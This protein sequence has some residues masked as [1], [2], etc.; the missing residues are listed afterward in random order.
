M[1]TFALANPGIV[2]TFDVDGH[3]TFTIDL[4]GPR[5][6][7]HTSEFFQRGIE[8]EE[9]R[10]SQGPVSWGVPVPADALVFGA[11]SAVVTGLSHQFWVGWLVG[12]HLHMQALMQLQPID[13]EL[14]S[15]DVPIFPAI[16]D[17]SG[18]ANLY[19]WRPGHDKTALCRYSFAGQIKTA[20]KV[21]T[22][23]LAEIPG[24][25]VVS[26]GGTIPGEQ[27]QHAVIGWVEATAEGAVL[28]MA[29]VMPDRM[30][31][32]RSEPV[33]GMAPFARQRLGIWAAAP[34]GTVGRVQ[35]TAALQSETEQLAYSVAV[36]DVGPDS[37]K[38]SVTLSD[39]GIPVGT[40][41]SAAFDYEKNQLDPFF[42]RT[43]L[44]RDGTLLTESPPQVRHQNIDLDSPL[45]VV[46]TSYT[47][48]GTRA[49]DGTMTFEWF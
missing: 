41:H 32:V 18:I 44:T 27:S 20:G 8:L 43:F 21:T 7:L 46:S 33:K 48:W 31:L 47:Y 17:R 4:L 49:A 15:D 35:L 23:A 25:P 34:P 28:A 40:L 42:C 11:T 3:Q 26:V 24:R 29:I 30:R 5:R 19:T 36:F 6:I 12:R 45:P 1:R 16:M 39:S 9:L 2:T 22:E 37:D 14:A 13:T 38:G 10:C